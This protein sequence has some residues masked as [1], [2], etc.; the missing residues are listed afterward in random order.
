MSDVNPPLT[1]WILFLSFIRYNQSCRVW[2]AINRYLSTLFGS[3]WLLMN[4]SMKCSLIL[5]SNCFLTSGMWAVRAPIMQI[6]GFV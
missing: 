6:Y 5:C 1:I 2:S 3:V 4:A